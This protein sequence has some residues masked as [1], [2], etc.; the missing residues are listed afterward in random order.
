MSKLLF[1][2]QVL[3][4]APAKSNETL[5]GT[6]KSLNNY[7]LAC[8]YFL[9]SSV[10]KVKTVLKRLETLLRLCLVLRTY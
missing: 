2:L 1:N 9:R 8:L 10:D 7:L 4:K 5:F 3:T 6:P